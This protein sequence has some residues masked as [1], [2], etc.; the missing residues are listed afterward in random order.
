VADPVDIEVLV[1]AVTRALGTVG[2]SALTAGEI[3]ALTADAL[4]DV[5]LYTGSVFGTTLEVIERDG[6]NV[7]TKYGTGRELTL[8]ETAMIRA[9]AALN[10]LFVVL[11]DEKVSE[12]IAD[13][14]QAWEWAKSAQLLRD[15]LKLLVDERNKALEA[16]ER[17]GAALD[18]YESF[19]AAQ[20]SYVSQR[21]EPYLDRWGAGDVGNN[22]LY[23]RSV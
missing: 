13:E 14:S 20:D 3:Y 11:R 2:A 21:I 5:M 19:V 15:Q 10:R 9:Q 1:P 7:P 18:A 17:Q 6:N 23:S 4:A 8:P 22:V 12:R 16:L